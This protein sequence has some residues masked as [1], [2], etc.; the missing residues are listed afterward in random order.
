[1]MV[2]EHVRRKY[3]IEYRERGMRDVLHKL[4]FSSKKPRP[5]HYKANRKYWSA[6]KKTP[7]RLSENTLQKD[8]KHSV[9]TSQPTAYLR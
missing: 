5:T 9:L 2:I 7:V 3:G 1:R 8:T 4:G 6:F